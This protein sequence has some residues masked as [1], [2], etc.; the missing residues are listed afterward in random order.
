MKKNGFDLYNLKDKKQVNQNHPQSEE[1]NHEKSPEIH[2][3]GCPFVIAADRL[4]TDI[5]GFRQFPNRG[6]LSNTTA[7]GHSNC[8]Q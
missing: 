7:S 1:K 5:S 8:D 4:C 3:T 2:F 6:L